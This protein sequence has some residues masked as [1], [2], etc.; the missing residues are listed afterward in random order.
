MP[1]PEEIKKI[2]EEYAE[3]T[4]GSPA[5]KAY[6]RAIAQCFTEWLSKNFYIVSRE[7]IKRQRLIVEHDKKMMLE[8]Q[9]PIGEQIALA[10]VYQ[11]KLELIDTFFGKS[12]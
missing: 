11:A 9:N 7:F 3:L 6:I 1:T 2:A 8:K 10:G 5:D 4:D 12:L